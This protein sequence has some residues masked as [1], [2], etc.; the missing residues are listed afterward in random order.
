MVSRFFPFYFIIHHLHRYHFYK[1]EFE[2]MKKKKF[3]YLTLTKTY[4]LIKN[5][6]VNNDKLLFFIKRLLNENAKASNEAIPFEDFSPI[7]YSPLLNSTLHNNI[8]T[9]V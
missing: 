9:Y 2:G 5:M 8:R 4:L 1:L 7:T 3:I 6:S